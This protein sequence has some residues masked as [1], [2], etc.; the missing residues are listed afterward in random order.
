MS[1]GIDDTI[2][3]P[4]TEVLALDLDGE[5]ELSQLPSGNKPI[6]CFIYR[7]GIIQEKVAYT[8]LVLQTIGFGVAHAGDNVVVEYYYEYGDSATLYIIDKNRFNGLFTLEAK[9]EMKGDTDGLSQTMLVTIP[10]MRIL[11][12][13]NLRLGETASPVV[14]VFTIMALSQKTPYS[15]SS[16][17]E[18]IQLQDD[19]IN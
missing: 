8:T 5:G 6:F 3:V 10:K 9:M 18:F 14:S 11:S 7:N 4:K 12:S 13:I 1:P 16:V 15:E 19:V 17:I 2:L